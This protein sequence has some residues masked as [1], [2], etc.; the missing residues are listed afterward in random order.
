MYINLFICIYV[1]PFYLFKPQFVMPWLQWRR[2]GEDGGRGGRGGRRAEDG[3]GGRG[4]GGNTS[5]SSVTNRGHETNLHHRTLASV[6]V[7]VHGNGSRR[8]TRLGNISAGDTPLL[9]GNTARAF[10]HT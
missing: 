8:G 3:G 4:R 6:F 9:S 7:Y 1:K 10:L 2:F 5:K